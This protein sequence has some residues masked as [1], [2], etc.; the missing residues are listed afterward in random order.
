MILWTI[1]PETVYRI[2]LECGVYHCDFG[3]SLFSDSKRQYDWLARQ[4][5][6]RI[7]PPPE[8]VDY[9]AWA[10]HTWEGKR[11]KPD[12]RSE[13]WRNG[14]KC[15]LFACL[16]IDIPDKD[17]LLSDFDSWSIILLNSM[18]C[19]TEKEDLELEKLYESLDPDK[20]RQLQDE[21]W[22]RVF[23]L[24]PC[25]N[26][27]I[28]RGRSIQ[29]TFWELRREQIRHVWFFTSATPKPACL[30]DDGNIISGM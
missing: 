24:T 2:I 7:S 29:A 6:D 26:G 23:D 5:A 4:M 17:V 30:D 13:R 10:W 19:E 22:K 20:Q 8:G 12:L 14:W 9:P 16:E 11:K 27:W 1:Q 21:N 28:T 15:D 18:I 25:D 3:K